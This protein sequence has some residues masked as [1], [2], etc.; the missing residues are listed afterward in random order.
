M[1]RVSMLASRCSRLG[2]AR[3]LASLYSK[4]TSRLA[5]RR[6]RFATHRVSTSQFVATPGETWGYDLATLGNEVS[7]ST[8]TGLCF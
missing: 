4:E 8:P 1:L 3:S 6:N 2:I 5:I 7:H